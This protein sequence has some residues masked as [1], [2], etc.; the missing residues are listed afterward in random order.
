MVEVTSD[1]VSRFALH[2][3]LCVKKLVYSKLVQ[4]WFAFGNQNY[5]PTFPLRFWGHITKS[6][7]QCLKDFRNVNSRSFRVLNSRS[8]PHP[9]LSQ[10][11]NSTYLNKIISRC[12]I[13]ILSC[14]LRHTCTSN[15][16]QAWECPRWSIAK[17]H[18]HGVLI[19]IWSTV[20]ALAV[21]LKWTRACK[22]DDEPEGSMWNSC[23]FDD[24]QSRLARGLEIMST[25]F[26][27]HG[28]G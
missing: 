14:S 8:K 23:G 13:S 15:C 11:G 27:G 1:S 7:H 3:D 25:L 18:S 28:G 26:Q 17:L 21:D 9:M 16:R 5:R 4:Y 6:E 22:S 2:I 10:W 24:S 20:F 19:V 12:H